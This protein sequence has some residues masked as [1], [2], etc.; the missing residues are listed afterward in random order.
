M[1]DKIR[2]LFQKYGI[3]LL[4][5]FGGVMMLVSGITGLVSKTSWN[6]ISVRIEHVEEDISTRNRSTSYTYYAVYE[7]DGKEYHNVLQGV[8]STQS[9]QVGDVVTVRINPSNPNEINSSTTLGIVIPIIVGILM[10]VL[11][12]SMSLQTIKKIQQERKQS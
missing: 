6:E 7:V 9:Y 10:L 11:G 4:I 8:D 3:P 1:G 5:L 12:I 2:T